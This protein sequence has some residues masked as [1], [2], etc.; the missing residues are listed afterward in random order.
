MSEST[1]ETETETGWGWPLN[2]KRAHYVT[3]GGRPLCGRWF[4]LGRP[5][6]D[7]HDSPDNCKALQALTGDARG[8][9]GVVMT[10]H[11]DIT[12]A[13][14]HKLIEYHGQGLLQAL[15]RMNALQPPE[16]DGER[17]SQRVMM[18]MAALCACIRQDP[19][20]GERT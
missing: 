11:T 16:T 17:E 5:I 13:D 18:G 14:C 20:Q 9:G 4:F 7:N 3:G 6:D 15:R 8:K 10:R 19:E 1:T 12:L 2:A